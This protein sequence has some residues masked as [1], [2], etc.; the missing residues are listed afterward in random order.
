MINKY[1]RF[2]S[3]L[4]VLLIFSHKSFSQSLELNDIISSS[5]INKDESTF[6]ENIVSS[7]EKK[8]VDEI[9]K[10][11]IFYEQNIEKLNRDSTNRR[12]SEICGNIIEPCGNII[13]P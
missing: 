8:L 10:K 5:I 7:D 11:R 2:S 6:T 9:I 4:F 13:E 3:F 12:T 1:L